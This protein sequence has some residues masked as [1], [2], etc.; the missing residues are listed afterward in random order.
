MERIVMLRNQ[1][2][3][4]DEEKLS[5]LLETAKSII[6]ARRFPFGSTL[7]DVE[8]MYRNLQVRIAVDLYNKQGAEGETSHSENGVNRTYQSSWVSEDLLKEIVP[9]A[10][11]L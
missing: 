10:G 3:D 8:P 11:I 2:P 4:E 5:E 9:K 7:T 1:V 6:F